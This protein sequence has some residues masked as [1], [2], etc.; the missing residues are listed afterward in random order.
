MGAMEVRIFQLSDKALVEKREIHRKCF[1]MPL[2]SPAARL[3]SQCILK[4][5]KSHGINNLA[6]W[7]AK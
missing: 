2:A 1:V 4:S 7:Q 6:S 3:L 5:Q